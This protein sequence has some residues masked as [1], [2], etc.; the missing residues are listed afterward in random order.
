VWNP[1]KWRTV[2]PATSDGGWGAVAD[3]EVAF[4]RPGQVAA[5]VGVMGLAGAMAV[6]PALIAFGAGSEAV[7]QVA[8]GLGS[9]AAVSGGGKVA[10]ATI[11]ALR[12]ATG[13]DERVSEAS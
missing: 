13:P 10:A 7:T 1:A 3:V 8:V 12:F 5:V 2:I 6:L 11:G 4:A 9:L